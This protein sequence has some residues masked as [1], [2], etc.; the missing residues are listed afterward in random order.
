[1]KQN[2]TLAA[3]HKRFE[4]ILEEMDALETSE[5]LEELNAQMEDTL[6]FIQSIDE[7]SPAAGE[8]IQEALEEVEGL[9][10][11]YR[12]LSQRRT[13]LRQ[14][15]QALQSTLEMAVRNLN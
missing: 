4:A 15:V 2:S 5:E 7:T 13:E 6:Y 14:Q 3:F 8:D 9:L 11:E 1:M 12:A 10:A